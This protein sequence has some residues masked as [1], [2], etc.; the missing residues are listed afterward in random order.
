MEIDRCGST[1]S[2]VKLISHWFKRAMTDHKEE[3]SFYITI[4]GLL[5]VGDLALI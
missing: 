2:E 1:R 5:E 4:S 3:L